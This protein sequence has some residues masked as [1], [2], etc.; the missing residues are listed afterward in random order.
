MESAPFTSSIYFG[1]SNV[2]IGPL[3]FTQSTTATLSSSSPYIQ[4]PLEAYNVIANYLAVNHECKVYSSGAL[5][6]DCDSNSKVGSFE[7]IYLYMGS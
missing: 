1:I 6:C 7:P 3:N 2:S 5:A 4:L